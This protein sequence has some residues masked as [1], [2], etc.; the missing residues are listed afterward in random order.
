MSRI[1]MYFD[2]IAPEYEFQGENLAIREFNALSEDIKISPEHIVYLD[3]QMRTKICS[4]FKHPKYNDYSFVLYSHPYGLG[5]TQLLFKN[6][7]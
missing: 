5:D 7:I 1:Y 6:M 3:Y 2:D 4:R